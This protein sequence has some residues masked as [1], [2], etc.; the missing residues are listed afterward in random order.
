MNGIGGHIEALELSC[1]TM[2]RE[3][4]E[5]TGIKEYLHW[6]QYAKLH[7]VDTSGEIWEVDIYRVVM[8]CL[9]HVC[10]TTE[11]GTVWQVPVPELK[12]W[13]VLSNLLYLIPMA[14][15]HIQGT[16]RCKYFDIKES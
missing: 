1:E 3:F 10:F 5:E 2:R 14:I 16:D 15:N 11:E 12:N 8:E 13:P 6:L 4:T 7:G 9:P